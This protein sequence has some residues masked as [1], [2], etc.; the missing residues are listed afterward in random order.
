MAALVGADHVHDPADWLEDITEHPPG[1]ADLTVAPGTRDEVV[2][3]MRWA[4]AEG[5]AVTPVVAG[6][7]VA[8]IAIPQGGHRRSTCGA[9]TA[10]RSTRTR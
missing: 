6:Y 10:S 3:V 2:A 8:G 4:A 1:K 7:N 9:S 5:V